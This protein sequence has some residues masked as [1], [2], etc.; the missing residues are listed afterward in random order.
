MDLHKVALYF[1][2][3]L[4][5]WPLSQLFQRLYESFFG[6]LRGVPGPWLARYTRLWEIAAVRRGDFERQNIN[7]HKRFGKVVRLAPD[8]YSIDDLDAIHV[9][10][11]HSTK[12]IKDR[13][14]DCF[15]DPS[16]SNLFA[17]RNVKEHSLQRRR[18][19]SLYS[20]TNLLSYESFIDRCT[21]TLLDKFSMFAEEGRRVHLAEFLQFY[22]FDVIGAITTGN[23][24]GLMSA[25]DDFDSV[26]SSIH[27]C[28]V[29]GSLVGLAPELHLW[30]VRIAGLL[31]C[32]L[33]TAPVQNYI[34][35]HIRLRRQGVTPDDQNDFLTK[36]L[37]L[38]AAGTNTP[39]DTLNSC[40]TN[41]VAGSD[42]TAI[43]LSA[44]MY[45]LVRNRSAFGTLRA[46][47]DRMAMERNISDPITYPQAQQCTYLQAVM[48]ETLR[49]H[50]A[51]GYPLLR[52]V[53]PGGAVIAGTFFPEGTTVGVNAW[54]AHYNED[55]WGK[56]AMHFRPERWLEA[57]AEQLKRMDA[58]SLP[59]GH[60]SRTCIGKHISLLEMNKVIPQLVRKFDFE[61]VDSE[62]WE[63]KTCWFC[64][65]SYYYYVKKRT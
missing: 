26:I 27:D 32:P 28:M 36:L 1:L 38:E 63:T 64:K 52:V 13:F 51:V 7:L 45:Y 15:G 14:Y 18:I 57:S 59:F 19:A 3:A 46:E 8:K 58:C 48:K 9:I 42:T 39:F 25:E 37:K 4:I 33:P 12:F 41:I 24:F 30:I 31:R 6:P 20:M 49:I 2:F 53:P 54:V 10:Y 61:F 56:D 47:I 65:P 11:G 40:T 43:T 62:E 23:P 16:T 44:C 50:S 22:A 55:I 5:I 29:Y 17:E 21:T 35:K 60:G 34:E